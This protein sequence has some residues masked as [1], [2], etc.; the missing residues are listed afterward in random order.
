LAPAGIPVVS[1]DKYEMNIVTVTGQ[2]TLTSSCKF[3]SGLD[4]GGFPPNV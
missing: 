1:R 3:A 4:I 2:T